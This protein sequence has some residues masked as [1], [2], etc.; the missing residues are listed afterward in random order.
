M[1]NND[2]LSNAPLG[3]TSRQPR[4]ASTDEFKEEFGDFRVNDITENLSDST[5]ENQPPEDDD[6]DDTDTISGQEENEVA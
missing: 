3:D 5:K 1:D 6:V 2:N 4:Y